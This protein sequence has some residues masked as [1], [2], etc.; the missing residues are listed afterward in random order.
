MGSPCF[1]AILGFIPEVCKI[2]YKFGLQTYVYKF[3]SKSHYSQLTPLVLPSLL[4]T[5][6][7]NSGNDHTNIF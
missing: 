2:V 4:E 5:T 1:D 3:C 6:I 7:T